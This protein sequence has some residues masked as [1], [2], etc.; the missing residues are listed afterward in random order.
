MGI[1]NYLPNLFRSTFVHVLLSTA[2]FS[3]QFQVFSL[4]CSR[5][6]LILIFYFFLHHEFIKGTYII[7][8]FGW[9]QDNNVCIFHAISLILNWTLF[10]IC[11][12]GLA[13]EISFSHHTI[14]NRQLL[15]SLYVGGATIN[16][17]LLFVESS[18]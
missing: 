6:T 4:Y 12:F 16:E 9:Q 13:L 18:C 15:A 17:H 3:S 10:L 8:C 2:S 14:F 5:W 7:V 11:L 1:N